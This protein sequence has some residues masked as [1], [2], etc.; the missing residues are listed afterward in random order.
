MFQIRRDCVEW[1][2][3]IIALIL[4]CILFFSGCS[5]IT[6]VVGHLAG[7]QGS[8]MKLGLA[9]SAA[10]PDLSACKAA[11]PRRD[12][13]TLGS[14]H[15]SGPPLWH[16]ASFL[17]CKILPANQLTL[18]ETVLQSK[19]K[20]VLRRVPSLC[21]PAAGTQ[22]DHTQ[23]YEPRLSSGGGVID[24]TQTPF[25][26]AAALREAHASSRSINPAESFYSFN[27][28]FE[29]APSNCWSS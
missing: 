14:A 7:E 18:A 3:P 20:E 2:I 26:L 15:V 21:A 16:L 1:V 4:F 5:H 28:P 25:A 23:P 6:T 9:A 8:D 29:M 27:A 10:A 12:P 22:S 13:R 24:F 19:M 11:L 17:N